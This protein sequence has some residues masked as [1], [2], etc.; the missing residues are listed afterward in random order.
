MEE[1]RIKEVSFCGY[2]AQLSFWFF[3]IATIAAGSF[4]GMILGHRA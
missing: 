2:R 3:G 1:R 4:L